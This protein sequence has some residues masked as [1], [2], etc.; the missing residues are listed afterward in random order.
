MMGIMASSTLRCEVRG[1]NVKA[2]PE[3]WVR[4]AWIRKMTEEFGFPRNLLAVEKE[5][6]SLSTENGSSLPKRRIDIVAY[7]AVQG[8][9]FP[10]LIME[11][12]AC[13]FSEKVFTQAISYNA[14]VKAPFVAVANAET[15]LLGSFQADVSQFCFKEGLASYQELLKALCT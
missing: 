12:K 11:C 2:T 8:H 15:V 1:L 4:Q 14:F 3:E 5:L 13:A 9:F 7:A 10:L 6:S